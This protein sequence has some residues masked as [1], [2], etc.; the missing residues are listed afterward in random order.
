[1]SNEKR[2]PK[3]ERSVKYQIDKPVPHSEGYWEDHPL[4]D[5]DNMHADSMEKLD[6][7]TKLQYWNK[8]KASSWIG[9]WWQQSQID[10]LKQKL[11]YY[12]QNKKH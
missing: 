1:M 11:R 10:K 6:I 12:E 3:Y 8:Y 7:K 4:D 9:K 5:H 2:I